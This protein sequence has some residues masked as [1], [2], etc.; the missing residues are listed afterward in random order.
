MTLKIHVAVL[1]I[2]LGGSPALVMFSAKRTDGLT[3][4][5][6]SKARTCQ[7]VSKRVLSEIRLNFVDI[8]IEFP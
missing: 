4:K 8:F 1:I 2:F 3:V 7:S 5:G 6:G